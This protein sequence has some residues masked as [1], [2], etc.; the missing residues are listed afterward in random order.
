MIARS[1]S[2]GGFCRMDLKTR[3][4]PGTAAF[5][6]ATLGWH[7]AVDEQ[8]RRRSTKITTG[9]GHRIGGVSD[10]AHPVHPPETRAHI[11]HYLTVD[12]VD[13]RT[14]TAVAA[15]ARLV[16]PPF[17]AGDQ[18][19]MATLVDPVGAAVS[20]WRPYRFGGWGFPSGVPGAP[21]RMVLACRQPDEAREFY[22][23]VTGTAF[24][25]RRLRHEGGEGHGKRGGR[26]GRG[27]RVTVGSPGRRRRLGGRRGPRP[28][29]GL[30]VG[31][32]WSPRVAA[33]QPGRAH[34]PGRPAPPPPRGPLRERP[35]GRFTTTRRP[36][37][38]PPY[39]L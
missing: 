4:L 9:T 12:D 38:P 25:P 19:R 17:D 39:R 37:G 14:A 8:D 31:G 32:R 35:P 28:W 30:T 3:D 11:A 16:V 18:G 27:G 1:G 34:P 24:N 13:R 23:G 22:R 33:D 7:F 2:P 21:H 5:F 20:F 26:G 36:Y 29:P 10:L 15:G 6:A